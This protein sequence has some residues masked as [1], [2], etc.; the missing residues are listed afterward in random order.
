MKLYIG[1][2]YQGQDRLALKENPEADLFLHFHETIRE[3]LSEGTDIR[4]FAEDF[5]KNHQ[6][7]V[8]VA[9]EI[10]CGIV[11]MDPMDRAWRESVGRALCIIAGHA[12]QVTRVTCGLGQRIKG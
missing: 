8:V 12:D 5:C 6:D 4:S 2:A 7:A 11:P 10:G 9:D 3:K 1:G